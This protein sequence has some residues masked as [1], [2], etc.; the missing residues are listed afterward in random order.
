LTP[1]IRGLL[2]IAVDAPSG[3][4]TIAPHLPPQWDSVAVDRV[5]VGSGHLSVVIRRTRG[6]ITA[7]VERYG[8]AG[9][10]LEVVFSPALPLG[11]R[12]M[13]TGVTPSVTPGDVHGTVSASIGRRAELRVDYAG[14]WSIVPPSM[15][16]VIGQRSE[17]PRLL[18]ERLGVDG[19]YVVALEGIAGRSYDFLLRAPDAATG[20]ALDMVM[21][22]GGSANLAPGRGVERLMTVTFPL[23]DPNADGYT[24]ATVSFGRPSR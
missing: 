23:T 18:S 16:A 17:A 4:V 14:G 13:G 1:L 3:R 15:P 11:A 10:A 8:M 5:P 24:P 19:R 22:G 20:A 7:T 21:T 2:G 12:V 6:R 9:G